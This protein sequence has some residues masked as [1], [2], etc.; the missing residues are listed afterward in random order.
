VSNEIG[1][2]SFEDMISFVEK[3]SKDDIKGL[4]QLV[5]GQAKIRENGAIV[6]KNSDLNES[7]DLKEKAHEIVNSFLS[8]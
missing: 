5:V 4:L 1:K 7:R 2:F 8:Y 6:Q 3:L